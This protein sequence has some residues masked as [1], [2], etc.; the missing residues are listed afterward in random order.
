MKLILASSSSYRQAQLKQLGLIFSCHSPDVDESV[1]KDKGLEPQ[2][3]SLK[4]SK[5]KAQA[6]LTHYPN[7]M[8]IGA[9]QVCAVNSS[10]LS[11]PGSFERALEQLES[12][13]GQTHSLFTSFCVM[14]KDREISQCIEAKLTMRSLTLQEIERYLKHDEPYQCCGSYRL[15]SLGISLFESIDCVDHT[16]II[17]LPLMTLS[18]TLRSIGLNL[19]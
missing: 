11:K 16:S 9:D 2:E 8:V 6:V 3:L 17:G 15:E 13:Q 18:Q 14:T 1:F 5:L 10:I 4:L 12:M 19:P 7:D